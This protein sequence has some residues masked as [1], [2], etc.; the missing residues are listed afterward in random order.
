MQTKLQ[1]TKMSG[2]G[3]VRVIEGRPLENRAV[4]EV[5]EG[6]GAVAFQAAMIGSNNLRGLIDGMTSCPRL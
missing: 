1:R 2:E 6:V 3:K 4:V 5:D